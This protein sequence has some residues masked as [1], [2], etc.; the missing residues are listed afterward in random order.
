MRRKKASNTTT[1]KPTVLSRRSFIKEIGIASVG[2]GLFLSPW[3]LHAGNAVQGNNTKAGTMEESKTMKL[4]QQNSI[5]DRTI[6]FIDA[7]A[8]AKTETATFSMG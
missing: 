6:P 1:N 3:N 4:A 5:T 7:A 8:P 2:C